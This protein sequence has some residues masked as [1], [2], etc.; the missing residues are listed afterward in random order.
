MLRSVDDLKGLSLRATDGEIGNV[1][2]FY[3][4]DE[5]WTIRYLVVNAGSWLVG[6]MVLISPI[7]LGKGD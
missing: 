1:D 4:D 7:S 3:F 6:R 5:T 2:Q